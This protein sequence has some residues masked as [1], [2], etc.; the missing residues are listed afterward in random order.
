[1][2]KSMLQE[3]DG[4]LISKENFIHDQRS[5]LGEKDKMIHNQKNEIDRLEKKSKMLEYKVI[6]IWISNT[7]VIISVMWGVKLNAAFFVSRLTSCRKPQIS[8]RRISVP[9]RMSWRAESRGCSGSSRKRSE[10]RHACKGWSRMKSSGGR[11]SV[12]VALLSLP[13][14]CWLSWKMLWFS[15]WK[16]KI[17]LLLTDIH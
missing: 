10:W 16:M 1:M 8:M 15:G 7:A 3:L 4:N 9:Y 17:W 13:L 11:R 14:S 5:K 2:L 12:W 6:L